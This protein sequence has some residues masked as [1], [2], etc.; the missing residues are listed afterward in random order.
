VRADSRPAHPDF[1]WGPV[2]KLEMETW[3][4]ERLPAQFRPRSSRRAPQVAWRPLAVGLAMLL[5]TGAVLA[6]QGAPGG[7]TT[8]VHFV[9][10]AAARLAPA[11]APA[12]TPVTPP[13]PRTVQSQPAAT[14]RQP[15]TAATP[16]PAPA[17][18]ATPSAGPSPTAEPTPTSQPSGLLQQLLSPSQPAPSPSPSQICLPVLRICL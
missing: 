11:P 14:P 10:T 7:V 13:P 15:A 18:A 9:T 6:R 2:I 8:A 12:A 16:L 4:P 1:P 3:Q 17:S 5:V